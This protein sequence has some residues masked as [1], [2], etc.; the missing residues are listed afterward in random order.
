MSMF[1][2]AERRRFAPAGDRL[3]PNMSIRT[4]SIAML[5]LISEVDQWC[6]TH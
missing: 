4:P 5:R 2:D 3:A 1:V 6:S